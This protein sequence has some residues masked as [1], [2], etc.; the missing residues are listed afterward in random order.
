MNS[1]FSSD[2]ERRPTFESLED[3]E[4]WN[5]EDLT[6]EEIQKYMSAK[7]EILFENSEV[8]AIKK[9]MLKARMAQE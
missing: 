2:P 3:D 7:G 6:P 9:E 1:F 5:G 8:A 4:W